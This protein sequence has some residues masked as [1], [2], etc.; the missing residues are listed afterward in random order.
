MATKPVL[1]L[2]ELQRLVLDEVRRF[3]EFAEVE[4][5]MPYVHER[6]IEGANWDL[7]IWRGPEQLAKAC[8]EAV[9]PAVRALRRRY[10]APDRP[11]G[12]GTIDQRL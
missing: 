1:M 7:N 12:L 4:P 5:G 11:P 10:D 3:A 9:A 8:K 6:D 2:E